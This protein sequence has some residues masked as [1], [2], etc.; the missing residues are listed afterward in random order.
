MVEWLISNIDAILV[1]VIATMI[2]GVIGR[3]VRTV[4]RIFARVVELPIQTLAYLTATFERKRSGIP[5]PWW[6]CIGG[7]M[8][9]LATGKMTLEDAAAIPQWL[10]KGILKRGNTMIANGRPPFF[11]IKTQDDEYIYWVVSMAPYGQSPI[12]AF[13]RRP[14]LIR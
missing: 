14:R 11:D 10:D 8:W 7:R 12:L 9:N 13:Y 1:A 5:Y 3:L 6:E 4:K 2:A